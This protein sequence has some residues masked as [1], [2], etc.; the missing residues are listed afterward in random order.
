[1]RLDTAIAPDNN[2]CLDLHERT[3]KTAVTYPATVE[4]HWFDDHN[5]APEIDISDADGSTFW[6]RHIS[7]HE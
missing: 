2:A 7:L 6:I 1:M 3:D 4:I 5:T